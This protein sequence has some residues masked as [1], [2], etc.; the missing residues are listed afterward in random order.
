MYSVSY[1]KNVCLLVKWIRKSKD[2]EVNKKTIN[3]GTE[4][5]KFSSQKR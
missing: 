3:Y 4:I 1:E 5:N 2:G